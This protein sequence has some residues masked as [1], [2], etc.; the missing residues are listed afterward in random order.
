MRV[1]PSLL[2]LAGVLGC[3]GSTARITPLDEDAGVADSGVTPGADGAADLDAG[4]ARDAA[5]DGAVVRDA[6][7]SDAQGADCTDPAECSG[8]TPICCAS[9]T[10]GAGTVPNC[11]LTSASAACRA[12]CRT[13]LPLACSSTITSRLCA[14]KTDC[15]D[16]GYGECC[17]FSQGAQSAT[18]C[19]NTLFARFASGGCK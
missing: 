10:T 3:S 16:P 11:P 7:E 15:V 18:L 5:S 1:L 14:A 17:T 4:A 19:V 8:A 12:T 13:S 6:G 2:V 9:I